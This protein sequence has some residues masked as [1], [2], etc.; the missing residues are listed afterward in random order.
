[1]TEES[2]V[3]ENLMTEQGYRPYCGNSEKIDRGKWNGWAGGTPPDYSRLPTHC[4]NP[5]TK[6]NGEQFICR[7]CGWV[8]EFPKEFIDK[9]K[10]KWNIKNVG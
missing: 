3:R 10:L 9:Y 4:S 6:F 1:M 8:S 7:E 2:I 5:R